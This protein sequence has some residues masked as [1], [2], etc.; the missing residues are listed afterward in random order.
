MM[1]EGEVTLYG[2]TLTAGDLLRRV[3]RLEQVAGIDPFVFDDGHERGVRALRVRTGTGFSF[4]VIPDRG[5]DIGAAE[6]NGMALAWSSPTGV[7]GP[8]YRE[9]EGE[10]WLRS[11]HGGLLVTCGLSNVGV[12]SAKDGEPLG[13]H[14]RI[15][16]I[17][18]SNVAYDA[19]WDREGCRLEVSGRARETSVFGPILRLERK[20]S[21]RVG[22]SWLQIEDAVW[23]EGYS[24]TPLMLLYHINLGWPLLDES[25]RL[26]S[27]GISDDAPEP[28]DADAAE[29]LN[30][31]NRFDTPVPGF[32]ER[33]FYHR[34]EADA[35]GWTEAR[36]ENPELAEG[37]A[38]RVRF[39]PEELPEFVQWTM[40]GEGTYV[41]GFEP[42]TCRVGGYEAERAAGRIID[43]GP[44]EMRRFRLQIGVDALTRP[45]NAR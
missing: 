21:T 40:I 34:P 17:P 19:V 7:V 16:S 41:V 5:L 38:L 43:L 31:W 18:A 15:S 35:E 2:R 4:T 8:W 36:L 39:R 1:A 45:G 23:N 12:P 33:V 3:G 27:P 28:R 26:V 24:T 22:T 25:S 13:L 44:K 9:P 42:S 10:G 11:F 14:G 29:G 37:V 20:I 30:S 6:Y 32:R